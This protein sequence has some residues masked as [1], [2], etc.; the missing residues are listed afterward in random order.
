MGDFNKNAMHRT[1]ETLGLTA[2]LAVLLLLLQKRVSWGSHEVGHTAKTK[3]QQLR[4]SN[5]LHSDAEHKRANQM[6]A[7]ASFPWSVV[8]LR[9]PSGDRWM[10]VWRSQSVN[11]PRAR[12]HVSGIWCLAIWRFAR[13]RLVSFAAVFWDITKETRVGSTF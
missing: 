3:T 12:K 1:L 5:C 6:V 8:Y 7:A 2:F 10:K 11:R 9:R 4:L 13:A